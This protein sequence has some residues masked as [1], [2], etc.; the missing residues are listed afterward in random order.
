LHERAKLDEMAVCF[1]N[2]PY[3]P[4]DITIGSFTERAPDAITGYQSSR[5]K[6]LRNFPHKIDTPYILPRRGFP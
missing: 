2:S 3:K 6:D 4:R 5:F 1:K